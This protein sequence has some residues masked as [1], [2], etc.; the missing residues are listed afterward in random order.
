MADLL[1]MLLI[2]VKIVIKSVLGRWL[3]MYICMCQ[4]VTE[5]ELYAAIKDG[6]VTLKQ[7]R[8]CLQV[9]NCCGGCTERVK[10]CVRGAL[11]RQAENEAVLMALLPEQA[12]AAPV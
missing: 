10:A 7:L 5:D 11:K 12:Q 8:K 9:A 2:C 4:A 6:A 3:P 1:I